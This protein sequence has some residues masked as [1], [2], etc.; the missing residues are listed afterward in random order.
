M[1]FEPVPANDERIAKE[2]IGAAIEV[3]RVLGPGFLEGIYRRALVHE[4]STR[5]FVTRH[6]HSVY[7][8]YKDIMLEGQRLDVLVA[9]RIIVEI[10]CADQFAPIHE[11]QLI[12][13][14]NPRDYGSDCCSISNFLA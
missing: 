10:K 7:V 8:P 11:A 12:P 2:T 9:E 13:T 1:Q 5:G 14:S 4:L 3:H 6:E